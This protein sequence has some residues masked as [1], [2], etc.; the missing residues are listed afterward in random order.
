LGTY[1]SSATQTGILFNKIITSHR[2]TVVEG[3]IRKMYYQKK[4]RQKTQECSARDR[5]CTVAK[6]ADK[7]PYHIVNSSFSSIVDLQEQYNPQA[8]KQTKNPTIATKPVSKSQLIL[9]KFKQKEHLDSL[10]FFATHHNCQNLTVGCHHIARK[11][12]RI[13][14]ALEN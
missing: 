14:H 8:T 5:S 3:G 13:H 2:I 4:D 9:R 7:L 12:F 10:L 1:S 11:C 6:R